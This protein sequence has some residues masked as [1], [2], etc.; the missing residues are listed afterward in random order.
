V[1][2]KETY[3]DYPGLATLMLL[4]AGGLSGQLSWIVSY[5]FDI[6]KTKIQCAVG[7]SSMRYT[8]VQI[9]NK[10]GLNGFWKGLLPTLVRTFMVNAIILPVYDILTQK[11]GTPLD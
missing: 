10:E 3:G 8:A 11:Y 9:Y 2:C 5:P 6:I 4:I 1:D 7:S